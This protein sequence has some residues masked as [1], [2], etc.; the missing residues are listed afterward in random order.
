MRGIIMFFRYDYIDLKGRK[1][2]M[3]SS[4]FPDKPRL[5]QS[6]NDLSPNRVNPKSTFTII[7]STT[8]AAKSK[9][10]LRLN[11]RGVK[12]FM[13]SN[14]GHE[15]SYKPSGCQKAMGC[16]N[17]APSSYSSHHLLQSPEA[18]EEETILTCYPD[19][20]ARNGL[21]DKDMR[22]VAEVIKGHAPNIKDA[23]LIQD[24]GCDQD[25]QSKG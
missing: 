23:A 14:G 15:K 25:I 6:E 21:E 2:S 20:A 10:S 17:H 8:D 5:T 11:L 1:R 24:F 16:H 12:K 19:Q 13:S 22:T 18:I 7:D 4:L 9:T 3:N